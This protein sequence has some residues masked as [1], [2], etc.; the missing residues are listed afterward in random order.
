MIRSTPNG[1]V[2]EGPSRA[3]PRTKSAKLP[4]GYHLQ[5]TLSAKDVKRIRLEPGDKL[6]VTVDSDMPQADVER[7]KVMV[8]D[9]LKVPTLIV[10]SP[11]VSVQIVKSDEH[12][13]IHS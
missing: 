13:E 10:A 5:P 3:R 4:R 7:T 11:E 12:V 1:L 2:D 8:E 6:L 9:V